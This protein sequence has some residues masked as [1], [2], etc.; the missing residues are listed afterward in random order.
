[1]SVH[2]EY[3]GLPKGKKPKVETWYAKVVGFYLDTTLADQGAHEVHLD[4]HPGAQ[5]VINWLHECKDVLKLIP[6]AAKGKD[7][8]MLKKAM[9]KKVYLLGEKESYIT[10]ENITGRQYVSLCYRLL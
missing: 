6:K 1:M 10:V 7:L 8:V 3:D 4:S 2:G 9:N 5:V